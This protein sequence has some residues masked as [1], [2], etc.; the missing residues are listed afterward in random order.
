M[1]DQNN[2]GVVTSYFPDDV[3]FLQARLYRFRRRCQDEILDHLV[4]GDGNLDHYY[5]SGFLKA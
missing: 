5:T 3:K 1:D 4:F 2:E